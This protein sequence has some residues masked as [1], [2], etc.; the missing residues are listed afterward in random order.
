MSE[1]GAHLFVGTAPLDIQNPAKSRAAATANAMDKA[2]QSCGVEVRS[3]VN[4]VR[5]ESS[6]NGYQYEIRYQS[7]LKTRPIVVN[8]FT[9]VK[10]YQGSDQVW[11][12][13]RV[14]L[15]E[16]ARIRRLLQGLTALALECSPKALCPPDLADRISDLAVAHGVHIASAHPSLIDLTKM[17]A[18]ARQYNVAYLLKV[19]IKAER[20]QT[21]GLE[22]YAWLD[23]TW[24]KLSTDTGKVIRDIVLG[25]IKGGQYSDEKAFRVALDKLLKKLNKRLGAQ[26]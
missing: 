17:K 14:P 12:M 21:I 20:T 4:M 6:N 9:V 26:L 19:G 8:E 2:V 15:G 10:R 5:Q 24:T 25:P 3:S 11:V 18:L 16:L 22:H 13:V 1:P 23:I 7:T